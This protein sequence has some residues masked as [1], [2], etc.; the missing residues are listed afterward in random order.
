MKIKQKSVLKSITS[1]YNIK[2]EKKEPEKRN[3]KIYIENEQKL[4]NFS[5]NL[6]DASNNNT[7]KNKNVIT[8]LSA[9]KISKTTNNKNKK[10]FYNKENEIN[11]ISQTRYKTIREKRIII[12]PKKS[13]YIKDNIPNFNKT[14]KKNI[15]KRK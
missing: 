10:L 8:P 4:K 7:S 11:K 3:K 2:I 12:T 9:N 13:Q 15:Y 5:Y 1:E 6:I 14:F